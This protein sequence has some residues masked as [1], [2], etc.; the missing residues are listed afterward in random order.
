MRMTF[1]IFKITSDLLE[2]EEHT[3]WFKNLLFQMLVINIF[4]M[5]RM[6]FFSQCTYTNKFCNFVNIINECGI[7]HKH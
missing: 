2:M 6:F 7:S 4:S 5:L 1:L 3:T